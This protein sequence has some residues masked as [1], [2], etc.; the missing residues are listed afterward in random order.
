MGPP[1]VWHSTGLFCCSAARSAARAGPWSGHRL[2]T[3]HRTHPGGR[4]PRN[5]PRSPGPGLLPLVLNFPRSWWKCPLL[6]LPSPP[7]QELAAPGA[8]SPAP[9]SLSGAQR[10][11]EPPRGG[12][13]IP[14]PLGWALQPRHHPTPRC[15]AEHSVT[16]TRPPCWRC[17]VVSVTTMSLSKC[18]WGPGKAKGAQETLPCP[19]LPPPTRGMPCPSCPRRGLPTVGIAQHC[20]DFKP[21]AFPHAPDLTDLRRRVPD[22]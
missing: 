14:L 22:R 2:G 11:P 13:R 21:A 19:E 16:G 15:R 8:S 9:A 4:T 18:R 10:A 3:W 17:G 20:P 6:A 12:S 5:Q 7:R 1:R